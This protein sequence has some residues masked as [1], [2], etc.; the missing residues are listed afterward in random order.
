MPE[1]TEGLQFTKE[2]RYL[3]N[4]FQATPPKTGLAAIADDLYYIVPTA[5]LMVCGM[6]YDMPGMVLGAYLTLLGFKI[7]EALYQA[8]YGQAYRSIFE[9]Y[10][11]YIES[12]L[13]EIQ[14][15]KSVQPATDSD[16]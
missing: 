7:R 12:L 10:D 1:R 4:Y 11:N 6:V 16:A 5:I 14:S 3:R 13:A 15:L 9:R 2:E 8:R